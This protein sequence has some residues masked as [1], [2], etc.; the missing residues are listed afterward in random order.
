MTGPRGLGYAALWLGA[1]VWLGW[2]AAGG[3][4]AQDESPPADALE[5][6]SE[7]LGQYAANF[8]TNHCPPGTTGKAKFL[9]SAAS[10]SRD[11]ATGHWLYLTPFMGAAIPTQAGADQAATFSTMVVVDYDPESGTCHVSSGDLYPFQMPIGAAQAAF[12][13]ATDQS[14]L[15]GDQTADLVVCRDVVD[16]QPQGVADSF[17]QISRIYAFLNYEELPEGTTAQVS[18]KRGGQEFSTGERELGGTGWV[19]FSVSTGRAAG[20]EPG[21]YEV[22]VTTGTRV[23]RKSFVVG[24]VAPPPAGGGTFAGQWDTSFGALTLTLAGNRATGT[25]VSEDGKIRGTVSADGKT[26]TGSWSEAPSYQPPQDAGR[27]IFKLSA[28]GNSFTGTWGY[29][30]G[31]QGSGWSGTR[32][33]G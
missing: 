33:G 1:A 11:P 28:D 24:S 27:F 6:V 30:D 31:G 23:A 14:G 17:D 4:F 5:V 26:L 22:T 15:P 3:S 18:W 7:G 2:V 10:W 32:A 9:G 19:W 21:Q 29:G 25:Y 8:F 20:Y 12:A 16:D 13:D